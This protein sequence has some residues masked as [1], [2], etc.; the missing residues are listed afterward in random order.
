MPA[1][2]H[3]PRRPTVH[4]DDR[5]PPRCATRALEELAVHRRAVGS[6]EDDHLRR[7]Q[8]VC[9]EVGRDMV[10][11]E[12][13]RRA[14]GGEHH[15]R[16]R[17]PLGTRGD[18]CDRRAV[19]GD[20][21]CPLHA[22]AGRALD[23]LRAIDGHGENVPAVDIVAARARVRIIDE[24]RAIRTRRDVLHHELARREEERRAAVPRDRV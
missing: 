17:R 13:A 15:G 8:L 14:A 22:V 9:R 4:E 7:H 11:S 10:G 19:A 24:I 6:A 5:R 12:E 3:L 2:E 23:R 16:K 1:E 21:R 18:E 20:V